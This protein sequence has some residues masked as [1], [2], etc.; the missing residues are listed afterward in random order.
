MHAIATTSTDHP[1]LFNLTVRSMLTLAMLVALLAAGSIHALDRWAARSAQAE[2]LLAQLRGELNGMAAL[3]WEAVAEGEVEEKIER[4]LVQHRE[5]VATLSASLQANPGASDVAELLEAFQRYMAVTHQQVELIR[6]DKVEEALALDKALVDPVFEA[7]HRKIDE[8]AQAN[9]AMAKRAE[10]LASWGMTLSM[11]GAAGVVGALFARFS[12]EQVRQAQALRAALSELGQAQDQ[13]VQSEKLA[14]LGQLIAGIAHEINTPLGAIRAA[15][16]NAQQALQACLAELPLLNQRLTN[17][18]QTAFFDLLRGPRGCSVA[19]AERRSMRKQLAIDLEAFGLVNARSSADMLLDMHLQA[20]LAKVV[21]LLQNPHREWVLKLA[22]DLSRL[23]ANG[24]TILQA[25]ERAAKVVFALK[26]YA[27][28]EPTGQAHAVDLRDGLETVLE[29]Y[30]SQLRQ[31]VRVE[32]HYADLPPIQGHADELVQVWTNLVHNAVQAMHGDGR[33][34]VSTR[35]TDC[36]HA[37]VS[38]I[39][40]GAGIAPDVLPRIFDAFYT[41]KPRGEGSGLGLHICRK[42]VSRHQGEIRVDTEP[43]RT[44]F[45]VWLPLGRPH[46]GPESSRTSVP[47]AQ[48]MHH[49]EEVTA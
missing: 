43:G 25:V 44:T 6:A 32:R 19:G 14:A 26:N 18:E 33:L 30:S 15:A 1:R 3:E 21:P 28:F 37:V 46:L 34:E 42:I 27:R 17:E 24:D 23:Q 8:Q 41:T 36:G 29:L 2:L 9:Q 11:L 10:N 5:A 22:Y 20:S 47:A 38:I 12:A 31:G 49:D 35:R 7:L 4:E 16:G 39:D 13:M 48:P 45:S 40:S